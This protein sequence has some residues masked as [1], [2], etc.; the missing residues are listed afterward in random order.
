MQI[1]TLL[2]S[3]LPPHNP[4]QDSESRA[5]FLRRRSSDDAADQSGNGSDDDS[6]SVSSVESRAS[7]SSLRS[8]A[9]SRAGRVDLHARFPLD[10]PQSSASPT[11]PELELTGGG[12]TEPSRTPEEMAAFL[13]HR[14]AHYGREFVKRPPP[15]EDEDDGSD[16][17]NKEEK[18][19]I[20]NSEMDA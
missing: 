10:A 20:D 9:S 13:A 11:L 19:D 18:G 17:D 14:R 3:P 4:A 16:G 5:R 1:Q 2:T 15:P 7:R 12:R 6:S 8:G